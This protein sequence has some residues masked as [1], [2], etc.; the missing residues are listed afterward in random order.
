MGRGEGRRA[1]C[2]RVWVEK[3]ERSRDSLGV[4]LLLV[5]GVR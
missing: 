5:V 4:W 3:E 2:P 1:F